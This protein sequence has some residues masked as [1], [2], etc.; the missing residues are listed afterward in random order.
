MG[1]HEE[2]LLLVGRNGHQVSTFKETFYF[3]DAVKSTDSI[4]NFENQN[5]I[6]GKRRKGGWVERWQAA[7]SRQHGQT[8]SEHR[9][10]PFQCL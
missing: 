2:N 3:D 5:M 7:G 8:F 9:P 4:L 6:E 1:Q 10:F